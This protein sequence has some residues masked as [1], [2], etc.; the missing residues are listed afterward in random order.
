MCQFTEPALKEKCISKSEKKVKN[1]EIAYQSLTK[2][3]KPQD[4]SEAFIYIQI[5]WKDEH[6][7]LFLV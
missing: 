7:Q 5:L 6:S 3:L 1:K 2:Q 4:G